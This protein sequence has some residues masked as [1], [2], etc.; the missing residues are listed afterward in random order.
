MGVKFGVPFPKGKSGF[1]KF[2]RR[3]LKRIFGPEIE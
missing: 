2:E 1:R 3:L